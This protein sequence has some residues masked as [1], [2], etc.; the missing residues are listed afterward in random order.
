MTMRENTVLLVVAEGVLTV[1]GVVGLCVGE[2]QLAY[3]AAGA[4][5]AL[6]AGHLNGRQGAT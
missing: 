6:L 2:P 3:T 4:C 5:A 1:L